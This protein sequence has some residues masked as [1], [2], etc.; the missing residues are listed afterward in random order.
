MSIL[1]KL[2]TIKDSFIIEEKPKKL[3]L[4]NPL[5]KTKVGRTI[6]NVRRA[7]NL[8]ERVKDYAASMD[9]TE[10]K[11]VLTKGEHIACNRTVYSH[12]G[13]YNGR[14]RV[15]EYNEGIIRLV[16]LSDFS[17]GDP[18]LLIKSSVIY[19]PD[20]I[21]RRARKRLGERDYNPIW[22]NCEH[23]ARWCR[24]EHFDSIFAE[25]DEEK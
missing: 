1:D 5:K 10:A 11:K 12:H 19:S 20:K 22:N 8:S 4:D 16:S 15:Y 9:I 18:I 24:N 6:E 25:D 21:I 17:A 13:I 3:P 14:S 7:T 23:Y 2:T